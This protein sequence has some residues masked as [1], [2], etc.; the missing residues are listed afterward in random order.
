M[1]TFSESG[2]VEVE[3]EQGD[4]CVTGQLVVHISGESYR[5]LK[6]FYGSKPAYADELDYDVDSIEWNG[7]S[8]TLRQLTEKLGEETDAWMARAIERAL[9]SI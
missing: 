4:E 6:G 3:I 5:D 7:E 1:G 2:R 9:D 8:V